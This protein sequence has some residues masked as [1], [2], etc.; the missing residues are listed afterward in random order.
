MLVGDCSL[1]GWPG[2]PQGGGVRDQAVVPR[3][4]LAAGRAVETK[5]RA[6]LLIAQHGEVLRELAR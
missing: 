5:L 6:L 3:E 2:Y 4:H 1:D